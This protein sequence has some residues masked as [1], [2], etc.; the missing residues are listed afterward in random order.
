MKL[1][2]KLLLLVIVPL[3]VIG[4]GVA[5]ISSYL[6]RK[7]MVQD[8]ENQLAVACEG[9]NGDVY[10]FKAQD[11][12]I[13][14]FEGDTRAISSIDGA[15]GTK[16]SDEV[17]QTTLNG[18]EIYFS[19]SA[20][21]NGQPYYGYYIPTEDGMLFAGKPQADVKA[22]LNSL[23][24]SIIVFAFAAVIIAGIIA[25]IIANK[26]ANAIS[27]ASNLVH[28]VA[29]GDLTVGMGITDMGKDE[30]AAMNN[31]VSTMVDNLRSVLKKTFD[32][33]EEV[34]KSSGNLR[35]TSGST[36]CACEEIARAIEDVAQNN[37]HQAGIANDITTGIGVMQEKTSN[38]SVS[39]DSIEGCSENLVNSCNDMRDKIA[40]TQENSGVMSDSIT[41]IKE[42]I[43]KTNKVIAKMAKI[44]ESI[45]DIADQT[46]LLSLNAS[47]EAAHAGESGKGF[48]VVADSI[49]TL[50]ENTGEEL[51]NI[52]DIITNIESDFKDCTES[53][54]VAVKNN[55]E[56]TKSI[57]DVIRS[58]ET[59]DTMIQETSRQVN[60]ISAA[61]DETNNQ[62]TSISGDVSTLGEVSESNAAASEQVNA[63]IE[64]LTALMNTVDE[65]TSVLVSEAQALQD[66]L[67]IFKLERGE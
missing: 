53:I 32:V 29:E 1:K 16:A 42:K 36:L 23:A 39:V 49:R 46:K 38:I 44:L 66:A 18:K 27:V 9:Y 55:E 4:L 59:V 12:D 19:D 35:E 3:L 48:A 61:V 33:S 34:L 22:T 41:N 56:S 58:F 28:Q 60:L 7:A 14:V 24:T 43:D 31:S 15:V 25:F 57:A 54:D 5:L 6:A 65:N 10:A 63:S 67:K 64:E 21:V 8:T 47:I 50:S 26:I 37:T 13:T 51:V 52:R 62:L 2:Q 20:N 30:I 17:I 40:D 11:I 45:E